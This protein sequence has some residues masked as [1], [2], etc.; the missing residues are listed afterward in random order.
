MPTVTICDCC[1]KMDSW[2]TVE[3]KDS[4][5]GCGETIHASELCQACMNRV[6]IKSTRFQ[7]MDYRDILAK[8][9]EINDE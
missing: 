2:Y 8:R 6:V 3:V 7:G 9:G 4:R 1:G 5:E